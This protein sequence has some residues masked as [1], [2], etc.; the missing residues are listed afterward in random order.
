ML[1]NFIFESPET[2]IYAALLSIIV[3][4]ILSFSLQ[5]HIKEWEEESRGFSPLKQAWEEIFSASFIFAFLFSMLTWYLSSGSLIILVMSA[6]V[7]Y[8]LI[9]SSYTDI[10]VHKAPR[11]VS[12]Y[13]FL[14]SSVFMVITLSMSYYDDYYS[15]VNITVNK[16]AMFEPIE[17]FDTLV[18]NQILNMALWFIIIFIVQLISRGGLGMADVRIFLLLGVS[19]SWWVGFNNMLVLFAAINI[20]QALIFIPGTIFK[21]GE[22]ITLKNGKQRRAIPFIPAISF[23]TL[24]ALVYFSYISEII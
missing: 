18:Q 21:W 17:V 9:F 7:S 20:V 23:V 19:L 1:K 5:N 10:S 15:M 12:N 16:D 22:M 2:I 24:S 6:T 4:F 14:I 13:S 3:L 8:T 11:E